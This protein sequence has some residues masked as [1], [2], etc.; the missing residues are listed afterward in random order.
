[1]LRTTVIVEMGK[2][3]IGKTSAHQG[4]G[5]FQHIRKHSFGGVFIIIIIMYNC[6]KHQVYKE[7]LSLKLSYTLR[8][9]ERTT[10]E[11]VMQT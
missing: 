10:R 2:H 7:W 9:K 1:M 4:W 5:G 11:A 8:S 6:G 3:F